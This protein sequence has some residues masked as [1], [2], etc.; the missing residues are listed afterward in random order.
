MSDITDN[1][2][3]VRRASRPVTELDDDLIFLDVEQGEYQV[4]RGT[5]RT[6]W[7]LLE[8][9][10]TVTDL[11]SDLATYYDIPAG[12]YREEILSFLEELVRLELIEV[13]S[14]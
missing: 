3:L 8:R 1:T 9:P 14:E 2:E 7:E 5:G 4:L 6:I 13:K 10:S 11:C 12:R